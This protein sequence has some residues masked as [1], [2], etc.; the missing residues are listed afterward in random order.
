MSLY[1]AETQR[2]VKRRFTRYFSLAALLLLL[3]V[4][5]GVFLT[6]RLDGPER[7]AEGRAK[8]EA[9][10]QRS[11]ADTQRF[12]AECEQA[13]GTPGFETNFPG[14]CEQITGPTKDQFQAEWY[15]APTFAFRDGFGDM[16]SAL[17]G[18]L[19]LVAFIIGASFVGAEWNSGGMMNLLLWRPQRL[20]VLGTKLAA[21][22]VALTALT[23]VASL[24]WTG[25]MWTVAVLRGN[26][27]AV[28]S[29]V[30][31]SF[32]LTGLRGL[33]LVL[34][35]GMIGFGL[36]SLGRGTAMALGAAIGV[37]VVFQFGL[38]TVLGLANRPF[39]EAYLVPTWGL[40]WMN[41]TVKLE[42]YDACNT[43]SFTGACEP[44]TLILTWQMAGGLLAAV[45]I[46]LVGAAM[47]TMRNRDVT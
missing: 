27:D 21:L 24:A 11:V 38:G 12:R 31:Q 22:L 15:M 13:K 16:Q 3:V 35:A 10:Y 19:A 39:L 5:V 23:V 28:T 4:A 41:K 17:A 37:V 9:E 14:G 6:N 45:V 47:W 32:A 29:G 1:K 20:K 44:D 18:I 42:N 40:A 43:A 30:W 2:L 46:L 26:T 7:V 33:V 8:A 34:A 25:I 36:A